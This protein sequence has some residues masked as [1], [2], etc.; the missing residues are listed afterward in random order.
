MPRFAGAR[1]I[2]HGE[3]KIAFT[4]DEEVG[5]GTDFFNVKNFNADF[6]YTVDGGFIGELNKETFSA[7]SATI[8]QW[9]PSSMSYELTEKKEED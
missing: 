7:D 8:K 2:P 4:P 5:R 6:A 3:I 9:K 1:G